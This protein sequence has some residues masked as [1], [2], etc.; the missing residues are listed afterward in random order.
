MSALAGTSI[1]AGVAGAPASSRAQSTERARQDTRAAQIAQRIQ[2]TAEL[3]RTELQT[4]DADAELPDN[5][6]PGY[7]QLW[8]NHPQTQADAEA[9][10]S[11]PEDNPKPVVGAEPAHRIDVT[12]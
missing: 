6:P 8:A 12:A 1:V 7:E 4:N 9:S 2:D 10:S 5:L 11:D 3:H